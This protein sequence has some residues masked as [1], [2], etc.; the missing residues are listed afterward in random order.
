MMNIAVRTNDRFVTVDGLNTRYMEEGSG[1]P[2]I[3]LHGSSLGSSADV[4]RRNLTALGSQGIR[5]IAFDLPG[6]GKTDPSEDLSGGYRKKFILRF[7][8]ALGLQKAVLI[9][10]SSSGNPVVSIALENPDRISH[11]MI[12]GTGS[13]LPP[14]ETG[15]TKVGGREGA[16]Q[17]RLEDRMVKKEP[18][19]DDTRSLLEANLFHHELITDEEL[20]LR[21]QSSIGRCFAEFVRRHA[22]GGE[23][24]GNKGG[25]KPAVPL[26]QRLVEIKQPL[27]LIYGRNDRARAEERATLLKERYPQLDLHFAEGCKHLVP[28]DAADLFHRLA[29]PFLTR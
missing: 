16:A 8:D 21:H 22:A 3:M 6:F 20:N 17:S 23:G 1:V 27:L 12:L 2:A 24:D 5:A 18:S 11:V 25:A 29:V 19:L 28:W 4:F 26:W 10:H 9:G 14:L 7:M 15:G 13:L